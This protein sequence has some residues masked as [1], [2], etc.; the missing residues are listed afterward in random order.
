MS[1]W[2]ATSLL[3]NG[4]CELVH[5]VCSHAYYACTHT[6]RYSCTLSNLMLITELSSNV[7]TIYSYIY[8]FILYNIYICMYHLNVFQFSTLPWENCQEQ[9]WCWWVMCM[10]VKYVYAKMLA[11]S[12][13]SIGIHVEIILQRSFRT[14]IH[15]Q[16]SGIRYSYLN[17]GTVS[18]WLL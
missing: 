8:N 13:F 5:Q 7:I 6:C 18:H 10:C 3:G 1:P 17:W 16:V 12:V 9:R 15:H 2:A 14:T 11:S 4:R